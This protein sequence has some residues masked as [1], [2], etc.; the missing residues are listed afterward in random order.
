[1]VNNEVGP[2][3]AG[4]SLLFARGGRPDADAVAA[5]AASA[6]EVVDFSISH[7]PAERPYWLEL[8][9]LGLTFDLQGL[10][11]GVAAAVPDASHAFAIPLAETRGL[12]AITVRPGPHLRAGSAMV[13]VVRAIAA[14]GCELSRLPGVVA[15]RWEP[16]GTVMYP[17]YF[18]RI[19]AGWLKG[20]VFPALGLTAL[21]RQPDGAMLT[22]GLSFFLGKEVRVDC[23]PGES[24]AE[25]ARFAARAIHDLVENRP[26]SPGAVTE[27]NGMVLHC[28][29]M[30]NTGILRIT[31]NSGVVT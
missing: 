24:P 12:E 18:R 23:L 14:L 16:A 3:Q 13:P 30:G 6:G 20:G 25:T 26:Y 27:A 21:V 22:E 4:V 8:L 5:L 1:M 2:R 7:R 15:V 17:D 11:P 19:V 31:R 28:E 9:V 29:E 10:A